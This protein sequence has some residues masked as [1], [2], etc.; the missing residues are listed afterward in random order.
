MT[1]SWSSVYKWRVHAVLVEDFS[2][3]EQSH[4]KRLNME[5]NMLGEALKRPLET[6]STSGTSIWTCYSGYCGYLAVDTNPDLPGVWGFHTNSLL[7]NK[8]PRTE[9]AVPPQARMTACVQEEHSM[10]CP[11]TGGSCQKQKTRF[12][13]SSSRWHMHG[14]Q[15][16]RGQQEVGWREQLSTD[17][18][19]KH[20]K[21]MTSPRLTFVRVTGQRRWGEAAVTCRFIIPWVWKDLGEA[22]KV[23][24]QQGQ[25]N[26]WVCPC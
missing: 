6:M 20:E 26:V 2:R 25:V 15:W 21:P 22:N 5:K 1:N 3:M 24:C 17:P 4:L 13:I 12:F 10:R 9:A 8:V 23:L 18:G 14:E 16:Q 11:E 19:E 7:V